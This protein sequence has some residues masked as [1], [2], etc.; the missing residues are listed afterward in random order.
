MD[1]GKGWLRTHWRTAAVLI[2]IFG[3]A[4]F[5]RVYFV[6][7]LA[8]QP[9]PSDCTAIYTLPVSG[10]S[11]SYYWDR[12]L[13][14]SFQ[15]GRDI[16][17][18]PMLNYPSGVQNPRLPLPPWFA[19]LTGRLLAPL[20]GNPWTAV[21]FTWL[22]SAALFGALT[23]FPTYALAKEAFGRKAGLISAL[24]LA[25]SAGHLQRSVAA[26]ARSA[27]LTLFFIVSTF[28][29]FLRALKTTNRRR[30]VDNWFHSSAIRTGFKA[31]FRE[32]SK[33]VLYALLA[34]L[35]I[36]GTA[37][38][39]QGWAYVIVILLV[40]F[41]AELFLDRFRNEETMGTWILF[42]LALAT[43]I[44]LAFQWYYTRGQI[45]VWFDV[46]T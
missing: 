1:D 13:C 30:W 9:V 44:V 40:W 15:S 33:S 19:L 34:G 4:L 5:L 27:A 37:L 3:L 31:F 18:D 20:F 11:D 14:Y 35:C 38:T 36:T 8:F 23:I 43:P 7:P 42:T 39:W 16:G 6:Y 22:F 2:L 32:N 41:A 10:G 26:D 29:F 45:R 25:I 12:A 24:L 21:M 17:L 46:P 28:Y